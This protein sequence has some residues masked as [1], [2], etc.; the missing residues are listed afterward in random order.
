MLR[1]GLPPPLE[2]PTLT[3]RTTKNLKVEGERPKEGTIGTIRDKIDLGYTLGYTGNYH[4][5]HCEGVQ[6]L[7]VAQLLLSITKQ[8]LLR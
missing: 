4:K 2:L 3:Q 8:K 1:S 6:S 5:G 7:T